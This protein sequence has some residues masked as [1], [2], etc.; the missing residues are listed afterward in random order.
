[1]SKYFLLSNLFS[2]III[3]SSGCFSSGNP[4][5]TNSGKQTKINQNIDPMQYY[6]AE[7]DFELTDIKAVQQK[8]R[9]T[10][11][12]DPVF[13]KSGGV[14]T[15]FKIWKSKSFIIIDTRYIFK[16]TQGAQTFYQKKNKTI[17]EGFKLYSQQDCPLK[18]CKIYYNTLEHPKLDITLKGLLYVFHDQSII[19]KVFA[20]SENSFA[21]LKPILQKLINKLSPKNNKK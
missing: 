4:K 9:N 15:G 10:D 11:F 16:T 12:K 21:S 3:F 2:I 17:T 14:H 8:N 5:T 13:I 20:A 19:Y 18:N 6:L 7:S 1:M